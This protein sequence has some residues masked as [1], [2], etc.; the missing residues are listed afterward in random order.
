[1]LDEIRKSEVEKLRAVFLEELYTG[2]EYVDTQIAAVLR[3]CWPAD[4][5]FRAYVWSS[6]VAY[7]LA[8]F[9]RLKPG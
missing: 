5:R 9:A 4:I 1:M 6:V 8:L 2:V 7:N 3:R